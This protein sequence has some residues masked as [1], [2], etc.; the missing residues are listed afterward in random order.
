M[1]DDKET[2]CC[3]RYSLLWVD[4]CWVYWETARVRRMEMYLHY[5]LW[6]LTLMKLDIQHALLS[7]N[8]LQ[9]VGFLTRKLTA[10]LIYSRHCC[11]F[12]CWNGSWHGCEMTTRQILDIAIN[13][14]SRRFS[15]TRQASLI[16]FWWS[17][18]LCICSVAAITTDVSGLPFGQLDH[19][20]CKTFPIFLW[21]KTSLTCIPFCSW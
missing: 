10:F 17:P 11:W 14:A 13:Y 1:T 15:T 16:V 3:S 20:C 18:L 7:I 4:W 5:Y 12:L 21:A 2:A 9:L 8:M 19:N 6:L